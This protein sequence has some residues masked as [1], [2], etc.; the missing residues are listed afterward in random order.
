MTSDTD[1]QTDTNLDTGPNADMTHTSATLQTLAASGDQTGWRVLDTARA[2]RFTGEI[3]FQVQPSIS[4]YFDE[5]VAYHAVR[6][7]DPSLCARLVE[8]GVLEPA[9]V[10]RGVIRVGNVENLGRLFDRDPSVDRDAVMV[11]LELATEDVVTTIANTVSGPF[12]LTAYRHH[13]SGVHRWFVSPSGSGEQPAQLTPVGEVAQIDG[14]VTGDLPSLAAAPADDGVQIEWDQ[15]LATDIDSVTPIHTVDDDL[16]TQLFGESD[17][18]ASLHA[19]VAETAPP[20]DLAPP[21]EIA[22][23]ADPTSAN[24]AAPDLAPSTEMGPPLITDAAPAVES[25]PAAAATSDLGPPVDAPLVSDLSPME[26]ALVPDPSFDSAPAIDAMPDISASGDVD[27]DFQILWPDGS[28]QHLTDIQVEP[29]SHDDMTAVATAPESVENAAT[30]HIAV[31]EAEAVVEA[32][33]PDETDAPTGFSFDMPSLAV[34]AGNVPEEQQSEDVVHAVR[35]ALEAI[36]AASASPARLQMVDVGSLPAFRP[37]T[38]LQFDVVDPLAHDAGDLPVDTAASIATPTDIT[39]STAT[40]QA[41]TDSR[42]AAASGVS[43]L[44]SAL[45]FDDA[46]SIAASPPSAP[47]GLG[48]FAPPTMNDSAEAVYARAA[49]SE[50]PSTGPASGVAS[51]VF[52]DEAP[53][54]S[55]DRSGA[56]KRLIDSLRRK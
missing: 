26:L 27:D 56:L 32:V 12:A 35:R 41:G 8:G 44:E 2:D 24:A 17:A 10:E 18:S 3:T 19:P 45:P 15:P 29:A 20:V 6:A 22:L 51:V 53:D 55:N 52:V 40:D 37:S 16:L 9:Q 34:S 39:A 14:S 4:V 49:A 47:A 31:P 13:V 21:A 36:E 48:G 42:P 30:A 25:L 43:A 11:V 7:G 50:Q 46:P 23:P 54:E 38:P 5:G 1:S 33:E 28:E